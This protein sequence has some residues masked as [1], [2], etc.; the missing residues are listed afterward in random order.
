MIEKYYTPEQQEQLRTRR[1]DLGQDGMRRAERAWAELIQAVKTEQSAGS[2]PTDPQV[3]D[4]ARQ[5]KQLIEQFTGGDEGIRD[6]IAR[7]YREQGAEVASRGMV[8]PELMQ[9]VGRALS[10]LGPS[11]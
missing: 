8:D 4:L 9:Y 2:D 5:W 11:G 6:S 7:M 10:E 3:L 1:E